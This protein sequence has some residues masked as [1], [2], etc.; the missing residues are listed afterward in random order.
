[1]DEAHIDH[2]HAMG[3]EVEV[4]VVGAAVELT[5]HARRRVEELEQ[6]WSRFRSDSE[7][8][9]LNRRA[10]EP[11]VVSTETYLLVTRAIAAWR[12]TG[13]A[14][15]PMLLGPI[16]EAGYGRSFELGPVTPSGPVPAV[17]APTDI[18]VD[19]PVVCLPAGTGF[20]PGGIGKGLAADLLV[21]ELVAAGAAGACVNLGGD[22][23][24][25]G[26]GPRGEA[27][28]VGIEHPWTPSPIATVGLHDGAVATSTTLRRAWTLDGRRQHHVIDPATGSAA[29]TDLT[30]ATV[31]AGEAWRAEVLAKAVLLR[32]SH[33]AFDLV[34]G[35]W[36]ALA[37]DRG[38]RVTVSEGFEAF[39]GERAVATRIARFLSTVTAT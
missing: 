12:L 20:D 11:V 9:V 27:W 34:D 4:I 32:G 13:G 1:M 16:V 5:G 30:L 31:V 29:E 21:A 28:T 2:F 6:L 26:T 19:G 38:G 33:R 3:S 25:A 23:R 36:A 35:T 15:D 22:L 39:I 10:G 37:V 7:I 8:S 17:T 18:I 14:F 24:V